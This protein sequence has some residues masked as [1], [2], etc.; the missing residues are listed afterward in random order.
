MHADLATYDWPQTSA[1]VSTH[2]FAVLHSLF[3]PEACA[4]IAA[5]YDEPQRFRSHIRMARYNFGQGEYKY[6]AYPLPDWL[7]SLR[8]ELYARLAPIGSEWA[9]VLRMEASYPET[10]TAYLARCHDAGQR[11]PTPLL[12]RYGASDYNCLHQDLYGDLWFPLQVV[13]LLDAPERDFAGGEL[14]VVEQRPRMQS[15]ASVISLKQGDAAVI[16][17]NHRPRLGSRGYSRVTLRHGVSTITRG[18]RR[19]LGVIFHDAA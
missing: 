2:G 17:V 3:A 7:A 9:N 1:D 13:V 5:L 16:A 19:T 6:F 18:Q 14:V 8:S 4:A 11:R 10:H 15:R 12:L